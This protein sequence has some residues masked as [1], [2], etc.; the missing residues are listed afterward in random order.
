MVWHRS[1]SLGR[2]VGFFL[3]CKYAPTAVFWDTMR[4]VHRM[5]TIGAALLLSNLCGC[6]STLPPSQPPKEEVSVAKQP[7]EL[8]DQSDHNQKKIAEN[9]N[10][11]NATVSEPLP[12]S[13]T[14]RNNQFAF[15]LYK[16][17]STQGGNRF[18]S[19]VSVSI[20]MAMTFAGAKGQT[21]QE[22][23]TV[24]RFPA[25]DNNFHTDYA[26]LQRRWQNKDIAQGPQLSIAN[27]LFA[28][29]DIKFGKDFLGVASDQ[30]QAPVALM[31]FKGHSEQARQ[32]IN[33]WVSDH[34]EHLIKELLFPG[35]VTSNTR[36][37]LINAIYFKGK[38]THPFLKSDTHKLPFH[39]T[40]SNTASVST[41][42]E[43]KTLGYT[44]NDDFQTLELPYRSKTKDHAMSLIVFLPK[45]ID[46]LTTLD[47]S[48][49]EKTF[50]KAVQNLRQTKVNVWLPKFT[51]SQ[52]EKLKDTLQSM[53]VKQAFNSS[54]AD[55]SGMTTDT[56]LYIDTI[57]HQATI[58]L[59]EQGTVAAAATGVGMALPPSM[60]PPI[61]NFRADHPF[62]FAIRDIQ[63]NSIL[64]MGRLTSPK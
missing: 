28:G 29:N 27:R 6:G 12:T 63:T 44:E 3:M 43:Q 13:L 38:W 2:E 33:N 53:G 37:M 50:T 55:F 35:I 51:F 23:A 4:I 40:K 62:L 49:S 8:V 56:K 24:L 9:T 26:N 64:F 16:K 54:R 59:D 15:A 5:T 11:K 58:E 32:K 14:E 21:R 57:V 19:P 22:M 17:L 1:N 7:T 61:P 39:T 20:A 36:M 42:F 46:G 60:P 48:I 41:M 47:K 31:D 52:S 10:P 18:F 45:K 34:T 30:Y 25:E